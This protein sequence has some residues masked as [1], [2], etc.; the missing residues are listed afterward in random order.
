MAQLKGKKQH[1]RRKDAKKKNNAGIDSE[2]NIQL[3]Q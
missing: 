2:H 3:T 1:K